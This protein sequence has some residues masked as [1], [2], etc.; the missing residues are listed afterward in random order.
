MNPEDGYPFWLFA[1]TEGV[2]AF[3]WHD[4]AHVDQ[5]DR[6][7]AACVSF[8]DGTE[9]IGIHAEPVIEAGEF[10]RKLAKVLA[11]RVIAVQ[12]KASTAAT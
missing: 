8:T 1:Q 12:P 6:R 2:V 10:V 7:L 4:V 3:E 5:D 9:R 11:L